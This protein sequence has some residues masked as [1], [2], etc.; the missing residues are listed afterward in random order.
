MNFAD[1]K[2]EVQTLVIDTPTAIQTL[3]GSF[4]NRAVKKL[5]VK[6]NYKVMEAEVSFTTDTGLADPRILGAR[7]TDWKMPRGNPY[8]IEDLGGFRELGWAPSKGEALARYGND[9]D[10]DYGAPAVIFEDDLPQ[11]FMTF[12]FPDGLSDYSDGEYRITI[13]YWKYLGSLISD[14]DTN[15]FT[16]NAEQW[17]IYQATAEGFYA[18]Q[19]EERAQIW[20]RRAQREYADVVRLD[21]VR[22]LGE[23]QDLVPHL[24]A[25]MPHLGRN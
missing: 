23:M 11:E 10:F 12:P 13:P 24:G 16:D 8:F 1:L 15:W 14:S 20:E 4:V 18:N 17:I 25:R 7:P 5:Q 22:R 21:K 6:H 3:V 19:D 2:T 9:A